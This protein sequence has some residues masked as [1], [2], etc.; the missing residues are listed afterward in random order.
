MTI[1]HPAA[2]RSRYVLGINSYLHDSSAALLRDGEIV[3]ATEEE[4]LS[5]VR[6]DNRFPVLSIRAALE[7]A[8]IGFSD[9]DAIAFGWNRPGVT[10]LHTLRASLS[11]KLPRSASYI[12]H[13]AKS[14]GLELY[15]GNGTRA[16]E[17]AFGPTGRTPVVH[18]DHH[19][20]H[21][22][23][24]YAPSGF[25]DALVIVADGRGAT[26]ATTLY[27]GRGEQLVPVR[28]YDYPNSLGSFYEAFTDVLGFERQSDEWKVMGLAAYGT[29][30]YDLSDVLRVTP[31]G[32]EL[33]AA[34]VHGRTW[35]DLSRMQ[36]RFG[37]RRRP[38]QG[39]K[40]ADRDLAASAQQQ[41]ERALFAVVEEGVRLTGSRRLAFA[42]GVAMNSKANG[43]LLEAGIVD[44]LFVQPAA[45]DDGAALGAAL[46]AHAELGISVPR[47]RM[48]HAYLGPS[49]DAESVQGY[50]DTY[51]LPYHR[52][53]N[54][55]QLTAAL[56]AEGDIVGWFQGRLEFGPRALG[57][58][59]ILGDPRRAAMKDRVNESVKFREGWRPFAPSVLAERASAYFEGCTDAPFMI[60]TFPVREEKR[61]VIPAVTH[62]DG[63]ARVQTVTRSA[64]PRYWTLLKEFEALT[65]VPVLMN[66]SFN[67]KGEPIVCTPHDAVRTFYSSGLD[68]LVMD[69]FIV[70]K[71]PA[72]TPEAIRKE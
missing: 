26:Q 10:P 33:D 41:L 4:R 32:Y 38:D 2:R 39:I 16:L 27:H 19:A 45:T 36:R 68:F 67:L 54:V 49:F 25:D 15:H 9:L 48:T 69:D 5:R 46:G 13:S 65:G 35:G 29:P 56:L 55:E 60:V 1:V 40:D 24:A 58:R 61:E 7:H 12:A 66:T 11:G 43:R 18:V 70:A 59:S 64:N 51:K 8:G 50:L 42:G 44:E 6:K 30:T 71:D 63:T 3:F 31:E 72:W 52:V 34:L 17:R 28:T 14:I 57:N 37:P 21:A 62:V 53:P 20:S 47:T 22:W 23:S